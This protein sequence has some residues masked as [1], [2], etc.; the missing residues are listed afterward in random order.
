MKIIDC[1][2]RGCGKRTVNCRISCGRY[3]VYHTAKMKDYAKRRK[4]YQAARDIAGHIGDAIL[5]AKRRSVKYTPKKNGK[6]KGG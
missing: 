5:R 3:K 1:P 4:E 6:I 2:C